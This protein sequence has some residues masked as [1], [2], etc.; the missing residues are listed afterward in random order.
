[1]R[2]P[3]PFYSHYYALFSLTHCAL[4]LSVGRS[5]L[6]FIELGNCLL[7]ELSFRFSI[8][9]KYESEITVF[10]ENLKQI[11]YILQN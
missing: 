7:S 1:M 2:T 3:R 6:A 10:V 11:Q 9:I 4:E 8:K 5:S